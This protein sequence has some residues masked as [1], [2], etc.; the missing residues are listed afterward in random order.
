[1]RKNMGRD[2]LVPTSKKL[3]LDSMEH[4]PSWEANSRSAG[5]KIPT[6]YGACMHSEGLTTDPY[7]EPDESSTHDYL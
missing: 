3:T 1:M 2:E 4:I 5:Q 6:C 7:P